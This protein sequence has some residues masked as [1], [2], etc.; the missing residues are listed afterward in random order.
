MTAVTQNWRYNMEWERLKLEFMSSHC[1][2]DSG[3]SH[4]DMKEDSSHLFK[5]HFNTI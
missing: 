2:G 3:G 5:L 1:V 4:V